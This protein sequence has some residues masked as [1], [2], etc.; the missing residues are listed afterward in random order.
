MTAPLTSFSIVAGKYLALLM[1]VASFLLVT[2]VYPISTSFFTDIPVAPL[3]T[4][5]LGL[6]LLAST[7]AAIGLFSSSLTSSSA[8]S[9]IMGVILNISLWFISQGKD[10]SNNPIFV[11]V[12]EYLS[13]GQHLTHFI[14]GSVVV[15]S[16][17]FFMSCI[18]FFLFLVHKVIEFS[19]WKS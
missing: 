2:L 9:V 3:V 17:V 12:I 6:F 14:K 15:S 1:I 8:L 10:F 16:V 13:L 11:E 19:R 7:Y 4:S 18:F 5:Y